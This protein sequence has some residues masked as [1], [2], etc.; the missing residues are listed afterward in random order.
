LRWAPVKDVSFYRARKK[1]LESRL[2]A[3]KKAR[4][5]EEAKKP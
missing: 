5:K 1:A 4:A 2:E 3:A